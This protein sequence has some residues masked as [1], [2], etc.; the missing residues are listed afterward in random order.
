MLDGL[1][2]AH[3]AINRLRAETDPAAPDTVFTNSLAAGCMSFQL[4]CH[5]AGARALAA[6]RGRLHEFAMRVLE[7]LSHGNV[8]SPLFWMNGPRTARV[9]INRSGKR[10]ATVPQS[11][12]TRPSCAPRSPT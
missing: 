11:K 10:T 9:A 3:M 12:G 7:H 4:R 2:A 8:S 6:P 1:P 5:T